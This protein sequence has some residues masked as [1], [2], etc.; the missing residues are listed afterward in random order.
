MPHCAKL[1]ANL[2]ALSIANNP[3]PR[4]PIP[5]KI[6]PSFE[7]CAN[8]DLADFAYAAALSYAE[9]ISGLLKGRFSWSMVKLYYS[10]FYSMM[11]NLIDDDVV[12][13]YN[14]SQLICDSRTGNLKNGGRSSHQWHWNSIRN[15]KRLS[16]WVYSL[17]SEDT[18]SKIRALREEAN[19][20]S[21]F[22]D[23]ER[24]KWLTFAIDNIERSF[25]VYRD[26][27]EKLYTYLDDHFPLAYP[28]QLIFDL[29][30]Q[31]KARNIRFDANKLSHI[32]RMWPIRD[33]P[34]L[35]GFH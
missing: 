21:A 35:E 18:Y 13:F 1:A 12:P 8:L 6:H 17:E 33:R 2:H 19:Y 20:K 28:T 9:G 3:D 15:I 25:R 14:K 23:P 26:D 16:K 24:P 32:R 27:K 10:C 22:S 11:F 4:T 34:P 31:I 5:L 30:G 29:E 7:E